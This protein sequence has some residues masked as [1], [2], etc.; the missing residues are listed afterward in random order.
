MTP[1]GGSLQTKGAQ[2]SEAAT[3]LQPLLV[4]EIQE[5]SAFPTA[6]ATPGTVLDLDMLTRRV[7]NSFQPGFPEPSLAAAEGHPAVPV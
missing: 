5:R 4:S 1:S 2:H 7:K 6:S 3:L